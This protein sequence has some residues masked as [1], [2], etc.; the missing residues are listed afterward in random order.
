MLHTD[1]LAAEVDSILV[2]AGN[3]LVEEDSILAAVGNTLEEEE[4]S[5]LVEEDIQVAHTD[6]Y[7]DEKKEEEPVDI[8]VVE[9]GHEEQNY[10]DQQVDAG[11]HIQFANVVVDQ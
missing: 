7:Q 5:I 3:I 8:L 1:T 11:Q 2:V 6:H 4:D 10:L 9:Q